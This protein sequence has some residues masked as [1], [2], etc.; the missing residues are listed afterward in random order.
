MRAGTSYLT[1]GNFTG[2]EAYAYPLTAMPVKYSLLMKN[3][4]ISERGTICRVP[5]YIKINSASVGVNLTSGYNYIKNDGTSMLLFAGGGKIFKYQSGELVEIKNDMDTSAKVY[6]SNFANNCI[7]SN[8]VD[9]PLRYDGTSFTEL[10][11]YDVTCYKS[12]VHKGRLWFIDNANRT[13][14]YHSGLNDFAKEGYI[15]FKYIL[16]E[17]DELV[18]MTTFVDLLVFFFKNHIAIYSFISH[19][20]QMKRGNQLPQPILDKNFISHMVQMKP[21][22]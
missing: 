9:R 18:D 6:F 11:D 14:A 1:L 20:V 7:I 13:I 17:G 8:G 2:G 16:P 5:G 12:H 19:M 21:S 22:F 4:Y 10:T 3:C 15:D